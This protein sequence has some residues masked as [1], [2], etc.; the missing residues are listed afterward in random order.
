M[1]LV[2]NFVYKIKYT[3]TRKQEITLIILN[4]Q[5]TFDIFLL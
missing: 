2:I 1:D 4:I 3:F 5:E